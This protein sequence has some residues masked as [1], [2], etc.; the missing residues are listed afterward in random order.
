MNLQKSYAS[1]K[2][3]IQKR[4]SEFRQ[5]WSQPDERIFAEL[6]FCFCTPQSKAK[7]CWSAV[8]QL[9]K[10]GDLYSGSSQEIRKTLRKNV[11]FH[12]NKA[13]YILHARE[14]FMENGSCR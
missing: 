1:R 6:A 2:K 13:S 5:A 3:E 12:N 9:E 4:I 14:L 11:R 10:S 8:S 7:A